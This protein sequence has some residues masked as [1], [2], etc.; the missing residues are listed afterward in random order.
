[1]T[2][3][4]FPAV[5][6]LDFT[7]LQ[8]LFNRFVEILSHTHEKVVIAIEMQVC[9]EGLTLPTE[10]HLRSNQSRK[11]GLNVTLQLNIQFK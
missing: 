10:I 4:E 5:L 7:Y 8:W 9:R 3:R 6:G 11:I 2:K 1:L